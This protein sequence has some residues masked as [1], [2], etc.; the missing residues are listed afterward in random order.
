MPHYKSPDGR[1]HFLTIEDV[2]NGWEG[3]LPPGSV[4]LTDE[5]AAEEIAQLQQSAQEVGQ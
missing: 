2:A 3:V 4:Q 1:I 5:Q